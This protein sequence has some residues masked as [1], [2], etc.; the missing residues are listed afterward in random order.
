MLAAK[1]ATIAQQ[2]QSIGEQERV[3]NRAAIKSLIRCTHFL[4]RQ[5]I[6]HSTNF[7]LLV[8]LVVSCG[9][10]DL[11]IFIENASRNAV[12]TSCAEVV[13]F[14]E[15]LGTWSGECVLKQLQKAFI[16]SI[17]F[18]KFW[19]GFVTHTPPVRCSNLPDS[20]Q[21]CQLPPSI[22]IIV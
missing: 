6:A 12:Y 1:S 13:D 18:F 20:L 21:I 14:I 19:K 8:D 15:T 4:T 16:F 9:V 5:P 7:T 11:Q 17:A 3:K 2:L 10:E 22:N